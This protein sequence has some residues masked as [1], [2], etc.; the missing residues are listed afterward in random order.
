MPVSRLYT[1]GSVSTRV[2]ATNREGIGRAGWNRER[3]DTDSCV[4]SEATMRCDIMMMRVVLRARGRQ[5]K[6]CVDAMARLMNR[7]RRG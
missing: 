2:I 5:C 4:A 3:Q 6:R 7:L 1:G